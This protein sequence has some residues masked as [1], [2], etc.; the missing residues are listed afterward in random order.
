MYLT[1]LADACRK[2]GLSVV[3]RPGWQSRGH[4]EMSGVRSIMCHHTAGPSEGDAPSLNYIQKNGLCHLVLSRSG[5][6]YVVQAGLGWHAGVVSRTDYSNKWS[7]GIEAEATGTDPWPSIQYDAYVVLA[8]I[9]ADHYKVPNSMIVGHK[10]AASPKGRKIDPN[11]DMAEFRIR[12]AGLNKQPS[13]VPNQNPILRRGMMNNPLVSKMQTWG[14]KWFPSYPSTPMSVDGDFGPG[15]EKFV[16]EFQ[17][18]VRLTADGVVGPNTWRKMY[19][20]GFR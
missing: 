12:V 4:G 5:G 15:T 18:R 14:N 13:P 7:I 11:F 16:K 9:L 10:E 20:H 2:S 17:S 6:V 8:R 19:E 3:E 1:D